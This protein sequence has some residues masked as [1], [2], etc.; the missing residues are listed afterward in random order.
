MKNWSVFVALLFAAG[1]LVAVACAPVAPAATPTEA[2]APA[3]K[4]AEPTKLPSAPAQAAAPTQASAAPLKKVDYPVAGKSIS[5]IV[6]FPA[7]G[8]ND[9]CARILSPLLE[10]KLGVPIQVVNKPGAGSQVGMTEV[11]KS[12]PDGY[13]IGQTSLPTNLTAY[14]D[15]KRKAAFGRADLEPVANCTASPVVVAVRAESPFKTLEDL[16]DA[17]KARPGQIKVSDSGLLTSPHMGTLLL[18]KAAGVEFAPVH[19]DGGAPAMTAALGGHV[20]AMTSVA[21]VVQSQVKSGA[22]RLL[23]TMDREESK[24]FPGVKPMAMQGYKAY[25]TAYYGVCAPGGTP[26]EIVDLLSRSIKAAMQNQEFNKKM[27]DLGQE[28]LYMDP[29]QFAAAWGEQEK[30]VKPLISLTY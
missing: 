27:E 16:V 23:A 26:K 3:A 1:T 10:N 13:T 6:P 8:S 25:L 18:G 14:L 5:F 11:A 22:I 20:D 15:P 19:F 12:K 7:G 21:P 28:P 9:I 30:D 29:A 24:L 2:T 4:A 17:A